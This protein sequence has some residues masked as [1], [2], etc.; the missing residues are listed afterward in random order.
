M[1]D[2]LDVPSEKEKKKNYV[3]KLTEDKETKNRH[4]FDKYLA[5]ITYLLLICARVLN[6]KTR[7]TE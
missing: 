3:S 1:T 2:L 6:E 7:D 4:N 5:G